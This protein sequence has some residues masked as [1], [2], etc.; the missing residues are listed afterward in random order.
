MRDTSCRAKPPVVLFHLRANGPAQRHSGVPLTPR[1]KAKGLAQVSLQTELGWG[2]P[3]L[4]AT[5]L[6]INGR[7]NRENAPA[8]LSRSN[9]SFAATFLMGDGSAR[10]PGLEICRVYTGRGHSGVHPES[11]PPQKDVQMLYKHRPNGCAAWSG[12]GQSSPGL[13]L[14]EQREAQRLQQMPDVPLEHVQMF[15]P[16][17]AGSEASRTW[18]PFCTS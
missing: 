18:A 14:W 1:R 2:H 4:L 13:G 9:Y 11:L 3:G 7:V 17:P 12:P 5:P 15:S 16:I 10:A 6:R 8:E